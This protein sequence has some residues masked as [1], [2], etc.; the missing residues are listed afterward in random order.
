MDHEQKTF[1]AEIRRRRIVINDMPPDVRLA[2]ASGA[3]LLLLALLLEVAHAHLGHD[4]YVGFKSGQGEEAFVPWGSVIAWMVGEWVI[5]TLIFA[6]VLRLKRAL[7][8]V[9]IIFLF[10]A[11]TLLLGAVDTRSLGILLGPA[12]LLAGYPAIRKGLLKARGSFVLAAVAAALPMATISLLYNTVRDS[13]LPA[14]F[15]TFSLVF[16]VIGLW[17]AGTDIAEIAQVA[18]ESLTGA[19]SPHL[20]T[21]DRSALFVSASLAVNL[22]ATWFVLRTTGTLHLIDR[23]HEAYTFLATAVAVLLLWAILSVNPRLQISPHLGYSTLLG[24]VVTYMAATL[25][26]TEFSILFPLLRWKRLDVGSINFDTIDNQFARHLLP[27]VTLVLLLLFLRFG[28]RS[29]RAFRILAFATCAVAF[30][31]TTSTQV[32]TS[33]LILGHSAA[34]GSVLLLLGAACVP[35]LRSRFVRLCALL[36]IAKLSLAALQMATLVFDAGPGR[37]EGQAAAS[38]AIVA[39]AL[40]WDILTSGD[41]TNGNTSGM[42]R[43]SRVAFFASYIITVG[44]LFMLMRT[45]LVFTLGRA[46]EPFN[47]EGYVAD[48][49]VIFGAPM[50]FYLFAI[51]LRSLLV[52]AS[53]AAPSRVEPR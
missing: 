5:L 12:L 50:I 43:F 22:T 29:T 45:G 19:C 21:A 36:A 49:I 53:P 7:L 1:L 23:H 39:I 15:V 41:L 48:G 44:L 37:F 52:E 26:F 35:R 27:I 47:S 3:L 17:M 14:I 2:A 18:A 28:R 10:F 51:Q 9:A 40:G 32:E 46:A 16:A 6:A 38:A 33:N 30:A 13:S 8:A 11:A 42:P 4:V 25:A 34:A 20:R 24:Y 31:C